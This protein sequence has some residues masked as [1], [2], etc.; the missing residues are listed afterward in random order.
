MK[1]KLVIG[2]LLF[3]MGASQAQVKEQYLNI[4]FGTG[5]HN[6]Q[7]DVQNGVQESK[8]GFTFNL[9]YNYFFNENWGVGTGIGIET[10][11]SRAILNFQ[12]MKPSVDT[13]DESFEF[14]TQYTDWT[15]KQNVLLLGI[16]LGIIY[17]IQL[18][19]NSKLQFNF[20]PKVSFNVGAKYEITKGSI[21]TTGYYPQY[22]VVL[23]DLP[24][25]NFKTITE[26]PK[27]DI[28]LNPSISAF[29]DLGGFY[30][31]NLNT[32][33]Y[34]GGYLNYGFNNLIDSK[35]NLLYQE[36]GIYNGVFA[37]DQTEKV[38]PVSYGIKL[39]LSFQFNRKKKVNI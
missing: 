5:I 31:L 18:N 37:S 27:E 36:D 38:I 34:F 32:E 12:T 6:L 39:G 26:F 13:D 8:E 3:G 33:L 23:F 9:G 14:R 25:H 2:M 24:Q 29:A 17:Q 4:N 1:L 35:N 20:G 30:R 7:Y 16:P 15:E 28:K 10:F 22:N 21:E 19:E 11:E